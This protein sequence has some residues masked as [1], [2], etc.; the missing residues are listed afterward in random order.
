MDIRTQK[1]LD[2]LA[3]Q[4]NVALDANV[5]LSVDIELANARIAELEAMVTELASKVPKE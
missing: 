3:H 5:Q 1:I 2:G 4:R